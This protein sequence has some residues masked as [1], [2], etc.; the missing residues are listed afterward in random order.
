M[1]SFSLASVL[2][3]FSRSRG[4]VSVIHNKITADEDTVR[5]SVPSR[6]ILPMQQHSGEPCIPTVKIGD[7]V[8]VGQ[9]VG[10]SDKLFSTPVHASVSG[11]VSEIR[12]I[13]L[14]TGK[15][16]AV[17]IESDKKMVLSEDIKPPEIS[18]KADLIRAVRES[19]LA[20]LGGKGFP[21][22]IKL[23]I[24]EDKKVDTLIVN[25][26]ESEPYITVDYREC[27]ENSWDILGGIKTL[28]EFLG[29]RKVIIA[30]E[31]NKPE[32]IRVL[33]NI[34]AN[35]VGA[36]GSISVMSLKSR[37]P[38]GAERMLVHSATGRKIP[39][40]GLP[41]D[42]GCMV[43]NV[44]GV[45]FISRYLKT[46]KPL[47]SRTITV[48][49]NCIK[50]PLNVRVPIG[51]TYK[52]II[53]FCGGFTDTPYKIISGGPMMGTAV[54]DLNI[55]I[56]KCNNAILAFSGENAKIKPEYDCIRCGRCHSA[57]PVKLMPSVLVKYADDNNYQQLAAK[58][59]AACMECGCCSYAC[60][61]G[62]PVTE[63]IRQ[64]K[65][66]MR[67]AGDL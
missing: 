35:S 23:D 59:I 44:S 9:I 51:T 22:H 17:I 49:G 58:G 19:G 62:R 52:D 25:A 11:T 16:A 38:A 45:A 48:S 6:I 27:L 47:T 7:Y 55:P 13:Q 65:Q 29:F 41:S 10:N 32:A 37:F 36:D 31:D 50:H 1:G 28:Q 61:A 63:T 21:T 40:G 60:P 57:C 24:P 56:I 26:A 5:I 33:G 8:K 53:D 43:I 18:D 64:A 67:K 34:A 3:L 2:R 15:A 42:V 4:G 30:I 66:I 39:A 12:D 14:P 20:G 46:G 54:T